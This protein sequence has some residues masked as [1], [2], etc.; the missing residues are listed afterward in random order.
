MSLMSGN[1]FGL[2]G[3][4]RIKIPNFLEEEVRCRG[5]DVLPSSNLLRVSFLNNLAI[6]LP[7]ESNETLYHLGGQGGYQGI[8]FGSN[9]GRYSLY[10]SGGCSPG[11]LQRHP[12]REY[13]PRAWLSPFYGNSAQGSSFQTGLNEIRCSWEQASVPQVNGEA[14]P[15]QGCYGG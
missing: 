12:G 11:V 10:Y 4:M 9:G 15:L 5:R 6:L 3:M 13:G 2:V 1:H 14:R 7:G 8:L